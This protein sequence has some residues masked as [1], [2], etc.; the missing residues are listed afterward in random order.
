MRASVRLP[1]YMTADERSVL[2]EWARREKRPLA[3]LVLE[4]ALRAARSPV[5]GVSVQESQVSVEDS[6]KAWMDRVG[7]WAADGA[8]WSLVTESGDT[9]RVVRLG[10]DVFTWNFVVTK[11]AMPL[12]TPSRRERRFKTWTA[13]GDAVRRAA[14]GKHEVRS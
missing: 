4:R 11:N 9:W 3:G 5:K 14:L 12:L 13:A 2:D 8:T 1:V 10:V 7:E 6:E